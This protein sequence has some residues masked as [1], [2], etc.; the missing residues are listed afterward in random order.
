MPNNQRH[1]QNYLILNKYYCSLFGFDNMEEFRS[2][3]K[4]TSEGISDNAQFYF[5]ESLKT[6][7]NLKLSPNDLDRYDEHIQEYL[8][9]IN[10]NRNARIEL[11][12][13]QYLAV[14]FTEIHLDRFFNDFDNYFDE[15]A[16]FVAEMNERDGYTASNG[17]PYPSI[18]SFK[19]LAYWSATGSGKTLLMHI[20]YLQIMRYLRTSNN[21]IPFDNILLITPNEGLSKQ[22][23]EELNLSSINNEL[24]DMQSLKLGLWSTELPM[25][26][27]RITQFK[28]EKETSGDGETVPVQAF[29]RKNIVFVD[30]GHKGNATGAKV[31]KSYREELV[32]DGGFTFE[33]SATFGEVADDTGVFNDYATSIIFDYR[34]KFFYEDGFGKDYNILNLKNKDDYENINLL[35]YFTGSLLSFYEQKLYFKQYQTNIRLFHIAP[36]LMIFVGSSV[37]G[38]KTSSD[39][40]TVITLMARFVLEEMRHK[41]LIR[42]ILLEGSSLEDA[43]GHPVFAAKFE[44][45]KESYKIKEQLSETEKVQ[46]IDKIYQEMRTELFQTSLA[47][48]L[49]LTKLEKAEGEIALSFGHEPFGVINIGDVKQFLKLVEKEDEN[50]NFITRQPAHMEES[51]FH[52]I[53]NKESKVNFLIGSKKFV[54]GWNTYR[55]TAM[56]LLNIAKKAGAQIIQLFGRG[57]RLRGY[58]NLLK[59][60]KAL[61][62]EGVLA[63]ED[64]PEHL[65]VMETLNIFGLNADYMETFKEALK[66]EGLDDYEKYFV[67]IRENIPDTPLL[68]V[69]Y[70]ETNPK[71]ETGNPAMSFSKKFIVVMP[72]HVFKAVTLD[73]TPKIEYI[74]S[75]YASGSSGGNSTLTVDKNKLDADIVNSFDDDRIYVELLKYRDLKGYN[76]LYFD[77]NTLKA[78]LKNEANY[79]IICA[80]DILKLDKDSHFNKFLKLED[81][82][83]QLLK[84][85]LDKIY[86]TEKRHWYQDNLQYT[87]VN[88]IHG[89]IPSEY[90]LTINTKQKVYKESDMNELK[91]K[92]MEFISDDLR[93][94]TKTFK[95]EKENIIQFIVENSHLFN[96]LLY[97]NK[98]DK[99]NFINISPVDLEESELRFINYLMKYITKFTPQ[100]YIYLLRNP[101]RKGIGFFETMGFYPDF[102][103]WKIVDNKH[104]IAFIEPHGMV[105]EKFDDNEKFNWAT[106]LP[107]LKDSIKANSTISN[108]DFNLH[109]FFLSVTKYDDLNWN[110]SKDGLKGKNIHFLE[111]GVDAIKEI[112]DKL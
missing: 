74:S 31:W 100:G 94:S 65:K 54:E 73:L 77:K 81:Y 61:Y 16:D 27:I 14:L 17:Y 105:H 101:S 60:S 82:A 69:P 109:V 85:M 50:D 99:F 23:M 106:W 7:K 57:V 91:K 56:G 19:K 30:E 6:L 80:P 25:K 55:V 20:N 12:Y 59:R 46:L 66:D 21:P 26:I 47:C 42:Q 5:T 97:K 83:I 87:A 40:L 72:D 92:L 9:H 93:Q 103:L 3:I 34:Y 79:D 15:F 102:I 112:F 90:T 41:M 89:L 29:G 53:E 64:I 108:I 84:L 78:L 62:N 37:T 111:D 24:F 88:N 86:K 2:I 58:R 67:T 22:H 45:L 70:V 107:Q 1:L 43:T 38:K 96:P 10:R 39:V 18:D 33:Y 75:K 28:D 51:L 49:E 11:K 52:N 44:F 13:F 110:I 32:K 4:K 76:N 63:E 35:E 71:I 36:P 68:Y 104:S 48:K 98:D 95:Y 8:Q